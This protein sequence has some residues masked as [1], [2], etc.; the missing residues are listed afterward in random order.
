MSADLFEQLVSKPQREIAGADASSRFDYQKNWAFC[1]M[2][3]RH[4]AGADYLV[5]FE[6]HDDVVFLAPS[7]AP[8][9][10]EFIQ[11]KT[12]RAAVPRKLSTL[13]SRKAKSNSI[14]GKMVTNF[15]GICSAHD[16]NVILV[17]NVAFEFAHADLSAKDL[18]KK[19]RDKI[20]Q[21]LKAE[22][23][24]FSEAHIDKIH[25]MITGVSLDAMHS[26]LHGVAME[27]FKGRFGEEHGLNVH[28]WV[29]LL[30]SE[31]VRKND[32]ASNAIKNVSELISKKCI[33]KEEV[34]SSLI[35]VSGKRRASPDMSL[36]NAELKDSGWAAND[37]MRLGK[38]MPVAAADYTD[39][40]NAEAANIVERL[41]KMFAAAMPLDLAQFIYEVEKKILP[42][43]NGPYRDRMYLAAMSIVA[44]HEKI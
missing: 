34:E 12:V 28:G 27:L 8:K 1:E 43:L 17:S 38:R 40:T 16:V 25:F 31:I 19:F 36:I 24:G 39:A 32:Y 22:L 4:M 2:L 37:L 6:F 33:G 23:P 7:A 18:A 20:I 30:K 15:A 44:Y 26:F 11:V 41:E 42:D 29:R 3:R 9:S 10:V 5:A 21:K 14:L 13:T 35:L